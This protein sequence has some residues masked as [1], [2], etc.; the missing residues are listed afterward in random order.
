MRNRLSAV[1][2][3]PS[4]AFGSEG[5][6]KVPA[7]HRSQARRRRRGVALVEFALIFLLLI[8]LAV[9]LMEFGRVVWSY[10]TLVHATR[11]GLRVAMI[12]GDRKPGV[13]WRGSIRYDFGRR[14]V[15]GY[16]S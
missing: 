1:S 7:Q 6:T 9:G 3:C 4:V 13:R 5:D 16:R 2:A 11:E 10:H 8:A 12:R 15:P 14:K